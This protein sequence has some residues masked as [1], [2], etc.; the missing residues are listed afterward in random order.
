ML[1]T[2]DNYLILT[3]TCLQSYFL[4]RFGMLLPPSRPA[5]HRAGWVNPVLTR[6]RSCK[7]VY[8]TVVD[9]CAVDLH[10]RHSLPSPSPV[11]RERGGCGAGGSFGSSSEGAGRAWSRVRA[12]LVTPGDSG[13]PSPA[14]RLVLLLGWVYRTEF[15]LHCVE[16]CITLHVYWCL[17]DY[18]D[19]SWLL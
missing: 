14:L 9:F 5:A 16:R 19:C 2:S 17:F 1:I 4:L 13:P 6:S 10:C 8:G 12:L 3:F 18:F 7:I 15:W 11:G